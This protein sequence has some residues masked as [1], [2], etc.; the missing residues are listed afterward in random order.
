MP[1]MVGILNVD[2]VGIV[3]ILIYTLC[4]HS[5]AFFWQWKVVC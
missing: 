2:N 3:K 4:I 1:L 5:S